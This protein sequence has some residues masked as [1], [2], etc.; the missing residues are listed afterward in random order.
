MTI[1]IRERAAFMAGERIDRGA[2]LLRDVAV[3]RPTS[4][5]GRRVYTHEAMADVARLLAGTRS[6]AG[7]S[8]K[9]DRPTDDLLGSFGPGRVADGMV[10]SDFHYLPAR[11]QFFEALAEHPPRHVGFSI[12]GRAQA[13]R[14]AGK[15]IVEAVTALDSVDL[16]TGAGAVTNLF[17]ARDPEEISLAEYGAALGLPRDRPPDLDDEAYLDLFRADSE[18]VRVEHYTV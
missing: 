2:R 1:E 13:R 10:R 8:P 12:Y 9:F 17:E 14:E 11:A 3:L 5:E 18:P 15:E 7:H 4:Q 16:V 6:F